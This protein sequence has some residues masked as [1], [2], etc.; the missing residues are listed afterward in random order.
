MP[1]ATARATAR[2]LDDA[3]ARRQLSERAR[4]LYAAR[5]DIRHTIAALREPDAAA[6]SP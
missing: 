4:A 5:F 1:E 6:V 3:S 2:L